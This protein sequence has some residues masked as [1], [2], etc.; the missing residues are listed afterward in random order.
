M[1]N[2]LLGTVFLSSRKRTVITFTAHVCLPFPALPALLFSDLYLPFTWVFYIENLKFPYTS[3]FYPL[4]SINWKAPLTHLSLVNSLVQFSQL[5]HVRL[6]A[7]PWTAAH[8]ASL[9]FTNF[10]SLLI[11]MSITSV[12]PSN[13]LILCCPLLLPPSIFPASG[14]F[15]IRWPKYWGF[16]FSIS[17]SNEYSG[18]ISFRMD[19]LT[20][21]IEN[22]KDASRKLL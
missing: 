15:Q 18:L 9:S 12:M 7:I 1:Q 13:H 17:P 14:S 6:F 4:Y 10:Q 22:P 5:S 20:L 11:L 21:Y 16:S 8:Q 2:C 19:W 3:G